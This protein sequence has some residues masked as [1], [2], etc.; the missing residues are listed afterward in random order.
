MV[1]GKTYP[2]ISQSDID[3]ISEE[4]I[5]T[6]CLHI[7]KIPCVIN[8]PFRKDSHASFSLYLDAKGKVKYLD[9]ATKEHGDIW[10]LLQKL[11]KCCYK[12]ALTRVC[13]LCMENNTAI[14]VQGH[15]AKRPLSCNSFSTEIMVKT[16]AWKDYDIQYW[17]SYGVSLP[18]LQYAEVFPIS[19]K[20]VV[21]T[22]RK[23]KEKSQ[24]TFKA[25]KYAYVF[26]ERKED[27][28]QLKIY[29]PFNTK[30]FKWC[31]KMDGS[32]VSLWT[33]VPQMGDRIVICSSLKDALCIRTQLGIPTLA[34]QG[35]GYNISDTAINELKRRFKKV[36]ISF[37]T[38]KAGI[39]DAKILAQKTGFVNIVPDL[40]SCKD[41]S[42]WYKSLYDKEDFQ[43]LNSLFT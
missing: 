7:T 8:S 19:H 42:D 43:K 25:D 34:L 33:K 10:N 30:G 9:F 38:D 21:K 29:Q 16:R 35:E 28:L 5:L 26:I 41:Y 1:V 15:H 4:N 27:N 39:E 3:N 13:S 6:A 36:F 17:S 40:G 24:I 12:E 14:Q 20:T 23:T 37:D 11:W 22:N 31:S 18:W 32:V 2:S